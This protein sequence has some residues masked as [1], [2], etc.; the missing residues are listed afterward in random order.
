MKLLSEEGEMM[1]K[2]CL[3][4]TALIRLIILVK[5]YIMQYDTHKVTFIYAP[6]RGLH[7]LFF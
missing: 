7:F 1:Y 3:I 2:F 4:L 5:K 6:S